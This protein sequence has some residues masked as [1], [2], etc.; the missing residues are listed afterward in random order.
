MNFEIKFKYDGEFDIINDNKMIER[1]KLVYNIQEK[2]GDYNKIFQIINKY[3]LLYPYLLRQSEESHYNYYFDYFKNINEYFLRYIKRNNLNYFSILKYNPSDKYFTSYFELFTKFSN[4]F[5]ISNNTKILEIT[6][7]TFACE[8][9]GYIYNNLFF[10]L[11]LCNTKDEELFKRLNIISRT[12]KKKIKEKINIL[13]NLDNKKYDLIILSPRAYNQYWTTPYS[14]YS[15]NKIRIL[16]LLK[17]ILKLNKHGNIVMRYYNYNTNVSKQIYYLFRK[18]FKKTKLY[19]PETNLLYYNSG[20]FIIGF[21]FLGCDYN[22]NNIINELEKFNDNNIKINNIE[23]FNDNIISTEYNGFI[24]NE[25]GDILTKHDIDKIK[26]LNNNNPNIYSFYNIQDNDKYNTKLN[27][28]YYKYINKVLFDLNNIDYYMNNQDELIKLKISKAVSWAIKYNFDIQEDFSY[29]D[30]SKDY[31]NDIINNVDLYTKQIFNDNNIYS[32]KYEINK[33]KIFNYTNLIDKIIKLNKKHELIAN[34]ID[35]RDFRVYRKV[36]LDFD[37]FY[38]KI[39]SYIKIDLDKR[40]LNQPFFKLYEML[41]LYKFTENKTSFKTFSFCELPGSF[42]FSLKYFIKTKTNI[43]NYQWKAQSLNETNIAKLDDSFNMLKKFKNNYDMGPKNN[44]NLLYDY[45]LDYY[46]KLIIKDN[47]DLITV[48]CGMPLKEDTC[49]IMNGLEAKILLLIL[50]TKK[51]GIIKIV[52]PFQINDKEN[53]IMI[54]LICKMYKDVYFYKSPQCYTS[55]EFYFIFKDHN[56]ENDYNDKIN[57]MK[58]NEIKKLEDLLDKDYYYSFY[59]IYKKLLNI[60]IKAIN[61]KLYLLDR[62]DMITK[63]EKLNDY[64]I[65]KNNE[66]LD[67][68]IKKFNFI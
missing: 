4:L 30:F 10:D 49:D 22:F 7:T 32:F 53:I 27:N 51:N 18:I 14:L 37:P 17:S 3:E 52:Y 42:I 46:E 2:Y 35:T 34:Y 48:D 31:I 60:K 15:S 66:I 68:W 56:K 9:L 8:A 55:N 38:H 63:N 21:D 39:K 28:Y 58:Y 54:G 62:Y 20:G 33:S 44:G 12:L 57:N 16:Y 50:K 26:K 59:K 36:R 6:N 41:E 23:K 29:F 47:Y 45:N 19:I 61:Y 43:T 65:K 11:F 64:I 40:Y 67:I 13:N 24:S 1:N 5:N 25:Y